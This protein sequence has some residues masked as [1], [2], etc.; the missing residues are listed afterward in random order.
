MRWGESLTSQSRETSLRLERS[1]NEHTSQTAATYEA[2][3]VFARAGEVVAAT[4]ESVMQHSD[5]FNQPRA[6]TG[7][8]GAARP[9]PEE[10]KATA[11]QMW[12]RQRKRHEGKQ[13]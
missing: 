1:P 3:L 10:N 7:P 9:R 2:E 11:Q 6:R 12:Q 4:C 8:N 13:S 5:T